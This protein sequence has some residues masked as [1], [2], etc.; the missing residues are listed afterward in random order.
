MATPQQPNY[1]PP[2]PPGYELKPITYEEKTKRKLENAK[3]YR[4]FWLPMSIFWGILAALDIV[5]EY[6]AGTLFQLSEIPLWILWLVFCFLYFLLYITQWDIKFLESCL[7]PV[8]AISS[9][10]KQIKKMILIAIGG[11]IIT[12][13][14]ISLFYN[15]IIQ[16]RFLVQLLVFGIAMFV[17]S[18]ACAFYF[19]IKKKE[20][21]K[22]I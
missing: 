18:I 22:Y 5:V 19:Q 4:K 8:N 20:C 9:Y 15:S 13:L 12:F 7:C 11:V 21:Q 16:E 17:T 1:Y 14:G 2:P 6:H 3:R 10:A